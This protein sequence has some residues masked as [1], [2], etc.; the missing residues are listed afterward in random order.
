MPSIRRDIEKRKGK[1]LANA[2]LLTD[3]VRKRAS[4]NWDTT[5][6]IRQWRKRDLRMVK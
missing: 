1:N 5:K 6:L 2:V 3:M 4:K